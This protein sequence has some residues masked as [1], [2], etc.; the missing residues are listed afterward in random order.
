MIN[1][2]NKDVG[3]VLLLDTLR[4]EKYE[5]AIA[6]AISST[7]LKP[8]IRARA[9]NGKCMYLVFKRGRNGNFILQTINLLQTDQFFE[10]R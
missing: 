3:K 5:I 6:I 4:E 2:Q 9:S 7:D 10:Y 8:S 1:F